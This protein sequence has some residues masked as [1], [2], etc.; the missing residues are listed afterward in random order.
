MMI[1]TS[2]NCWINADK[3]SAV[4]V[5]HENKS[6][7]IDFIEVM[8]VGASLPKKIENPV[9]IIEILDFLEIKRSGVF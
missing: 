4:R 6:Q 3:I 7:V 5:V 2:P 1:Q 8:M 9:A